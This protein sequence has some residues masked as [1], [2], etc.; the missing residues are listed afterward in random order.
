MQQQTHFSLTL[1]RNS[2]TM[3]DSRIVVIS[4]L[5]IIISFLMICAIVTMSH[6]SS[7][8]TIVSSGWVAVIGASFIFGATGIPMKACGVEDSDKDP[9]IFSLYSTFGIIIV[10]FP[11]LVYLLA[12]NQFKFYPWAILGSLD[13]IVITYLAFIAVRETGYAKAPAIWCSVG[14]ITSFI[15]GLLLFHEPIHI[16]SYEVTAIALLIIGVV[17]VNFCQSEQ[18]STHEVQSS[19]DHWLSPLS[20]WS[21][22][23]VDDLTAHD[24]HSAAA[25][26]HAGIELNS[27]RRHITSSSSSSSSGKM[28]RPPLLDSHHSK[29]PASSSIM[30]L[31]SSSSSSSG[32]ASHH[33]HHHQYHHEWNLVAVTDDSL[34]DP[35]GG[36]QVGVGMDS[37]SMDIESCTHPQPPH[38]NSSSNSSSNS[39][40]RLYPII[41]NGPS[42][43]SFDS[44]EHHFRTPPIGAGHSRSRP[45]TAS[46][47]DPMKQETRDEDDDDDD[48]DGGGS[49]DAETEELS[50]NPLHA[51][52]TTTT[53]EAA[54][55]S[56]RIASSPCCQYELS[57]SIDG[58]SSSRISN[59]SSSSSMIINFEESDGTYDQSSRH[60]IAALLSPPITTPII[61]IIIIIP[62]N[63]EIMGIRIPLYGVGVCVLMGVCDGSLMAPFK[64]S[65]ATT[66]EDILCYLASFCLGSMLVAP[67][68]LL[69]Y[70]LYIYKRE[71]DNYYYHTSSSS[72][73]SS[74]AAAVPS[75]SAFE[76]SLAIMAKKMG[77]SPTLGTMMGILWASGNFMSVHA[78]YYLGRLGA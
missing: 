48:D 26:I 37:S 49:D 70:Y 2:D 36:K 61:P 31:M 69:M 54:D 59:S 73:S 10:N 66:I 27:I 67:A 72:S 42:N 62:S 65:R 45:D 53:I 3:G 4:I 30:G 38:N 23:S 52:T 57:M 34:V 16:V 25:A 50:W 47:K 24:D 28:N 39:S 7:H 77:A 12:T 9:L 14:M 71:V 76:Q 78:T 17:T 33:H 64:L 51:A 11:V 15:Q 20:E 32:R 46:L 43:D 13:I 22:V 29:Y 55:S 60:S 41:Y 74:S 35:I 1:D 21:T 75:Y 40:G 5:M 68:I 63:I 18:Q 6:S 56:R 44:S 19:L 8:T 58:S